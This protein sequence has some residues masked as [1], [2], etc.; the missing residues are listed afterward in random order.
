M[1]RRRQQK[2]R[3]PGPNCHHNRSLL[4]VTPDW[5]LV[6]VQGWDSG[7]AMGWERD[8]VK[9]LDWVQDSD[10]VKGWVSVLAQVGAESFRCHRRL[11][12]HKRP[13]RIAPQGRPASSCF[14]CRLD[15]LVHSRS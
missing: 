11:P 9:D 1:N 6:W 4:A 8:L 14:P 12:R 7:L 15:Y 3:H 2:H 5:V 10:S 13:V